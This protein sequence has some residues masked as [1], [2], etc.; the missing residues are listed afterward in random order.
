M[1]PDISERSF[2]EAIEYG[3]LQDGPDA[4]DGSPARVR[5]PT[6]PSVYTPPGGYLKRPE[7]L[8]ISTF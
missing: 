1:T 7:T 6:S 5:E 8:I 2:E 4:G 3:L